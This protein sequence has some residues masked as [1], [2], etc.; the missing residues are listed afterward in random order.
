MDQRLMMA[1]GISLACHLL[2]LG[3]QLVRIHWIQPRQAQQALEVIYEYQVAEQELHRLQQQVAQLSQDPGTLPGIQ[4]PAPRIRI[5]DRPTMNLSAA[6]S[7][8]DVVRSTVVDLTNLAEASHG[9]PVLLSYFSAIREQIQKTA[10]R[11]TWISGDPGQGLIYVSFVLD[12]SGRI[13]S[14]SIL[15][16]RSS[17][18]SRLREIALRIVTHSSPL[19]PFPPSLVESSKTIVVPLEFLPGSS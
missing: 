17:P 6:L 1:F 3:F 16:D 14:A 13:S 15:S 9:D 12:E 18:S 5:P 10:N 19:V 8:V 2:F 7:H 4:T 11:Q